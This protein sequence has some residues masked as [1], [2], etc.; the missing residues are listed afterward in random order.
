MITMTYLMIHG[1]AHGAWCWAPLLSWLESPVLAIDLP[2]RGRRPAR[3]DE[4]SYATFCASAEADVLRSD[5]HN[6]V[7]VAH[8]MGGITAIGLMERIPERIRHVI[9]V[10]APIPT[11]GESIGDLMQR[12]TMISSAQKQAHSAID[13][14]VANPG[15]AEILCHDLT[16]VDRAFCLS[17]ISAESIAAFNEPV[18][19]AGLGGK[20]P[21]T[22]IRTLKDRALTP[23]LQQESI[24]RIPQVRVRDLDTG[25][26][27]MFADPQGLA[28]LIATV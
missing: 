11:D 6:V 4:Q 2:G 12:R 18:R 26:T 15:L 5:L 23:E 7:I 13:S 17:R 28:H 9:F 14:G 16:P 1:G 24:A 27:A 8:S 22:Y 21:R 10:A 20:I 3:L 25:H 19:L